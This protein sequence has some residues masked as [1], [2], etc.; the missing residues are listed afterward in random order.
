MQARYLVA[1][2]LLLLSACAP[3]KDTPYLEDE[4]GKA[5]QAAFDAQIVN[6]CNPNAEKLPVGMAGI[7]AEEVM[8]VK[9]KMFAEKINKGQIVEFGMQGSR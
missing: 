1:G 2:A 5:S 4:F 9:N 6:K 3:F 8:G 7:T